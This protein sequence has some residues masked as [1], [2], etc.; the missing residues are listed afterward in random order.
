MYMVLTPPEGGETEFASTATAYE[1]LDAD[2]QVGTPVLLATVTCHHCPCNKCLHT[3]HAAEQAC[4]CPSVEGA[5]SIS[6]AA[7][8]ARAE[9]RV[10]GD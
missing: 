1:N 4:S 7:V 9:R 5:V 8:A 2:T 3:D 6:K 10:V